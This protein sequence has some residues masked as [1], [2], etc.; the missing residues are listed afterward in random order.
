M[1]EDEVRGYGMQILAKKEGF[2]HRLHNCEDQNKASIFF[3]PYPAKV[4]LHIM[5][6]T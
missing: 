3:H 5:Q 2:V 1:G 4:M 6:A